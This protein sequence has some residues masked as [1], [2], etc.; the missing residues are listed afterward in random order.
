MGYSAAALAVAAIG[1]AV[2]A[3]QAKPKLQDPTPPPQASQ[4]PDANGVLQ[5][6]RGTGQAGGAPGAAQTMLTGPGGVNP[7][8]L[9]LGKSTLLGS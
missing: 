8:A 2:S 3:S 1:T 9:T 7:D 6:M 5:N 4:G